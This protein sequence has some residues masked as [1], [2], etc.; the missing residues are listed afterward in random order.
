MKKLFIISVALLIISVGSLGV[1]L[2]LFKMQGYEK[3]AI[4][5]KSKT[6]IVY[7]KPQSVYLSTPDK[8]VQSYWEY[9]DYVRRETDRKQKEFLGKAEQYIMPI[10]KSFVETFLA[11]ELLQ[12]RLKKLGPSQAPEIEKQYRRVIEEV[13]LETD[14]RAKVQFMVYNITPL[15]ILKPPLQAEELQKIIKERENGSLFVYTLEKFSDRWKIV[16]RKRWEKDPSGSE[17]WKWSELD[18]NEGGF[19]LDLWEAV[20]VLDHEN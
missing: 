13:K 19:R 6:R 9:L 16:E 14:T 18:M 12:A 2:Y 15:D 8:T 10:E 1:A 20:S 7:K 4:G 11:G 5:E 3:S 17:E